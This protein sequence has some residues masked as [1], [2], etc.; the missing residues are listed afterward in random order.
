MSNGQWVQDSGERRVLGHRCRTDITIIRLSSWFCPSGPGA[1]NVERVS[2]P[3]DT[4]QCLE[5][6]LSVTVGRVR[7]LAE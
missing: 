5:M 3:R 1:V 7:H 4:G 6:H 2:L